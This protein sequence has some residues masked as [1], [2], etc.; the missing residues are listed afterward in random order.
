MQQLQ[1]F[2]PRILLDL[3]CHL[4]LRLEFVLYES[5]SLL[6]SPSSNAKAVLN[7]PNP[8]PGLTNR[9][10]NRWSCSTILLRYLTGRSSEVLGRVS[11]A[12]NS[13]IAGWG[14]S[15]ILIHIYDS[16]YSELQA[17][18]FWFAFDS[19]YGAAGSAAALTACDRGKETLM[20]EKMQQPGGNSLVS[21]ANMIFPKNTADADK[22]A[23][24]LRDCL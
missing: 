3:K 11:S 8:I 15:G 10:M 20:L 23:D 9:R 24:Y 21:S 14:I 1:K 19:G 18:L 4:F 16:R 17:R 6:R 2:D 12:F 22:L 7:E 13:S 5:C